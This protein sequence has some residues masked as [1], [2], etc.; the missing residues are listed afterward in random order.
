VLKKSLLPREKLARMRLKRK[1]FT[2]L[3]QAA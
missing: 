1:A 3:K 2:G